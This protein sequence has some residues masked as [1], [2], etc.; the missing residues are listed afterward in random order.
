MK[1]QSTYIAQPVPNVINTD[2]RMSRKK[3]WSTVWC[4]IHTLKVADVKR[5]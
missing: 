1:Q 3:A 2:I 4:R 5:G